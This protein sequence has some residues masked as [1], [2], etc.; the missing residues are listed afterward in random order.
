MT[1][2][3]T[4]AR[5]QIEK[6]IQLYKKFDANERKAMTD[7][8]VVHQFAD[9]T[10]GGVGRSVDAGQRRHGPRRAPAVAQP[11]GRAGRPSLRAESH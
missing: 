3:Q 10:A 5:Q 2:E 4:A 6:L 1:P 7:A 11:T 9:P 8:G